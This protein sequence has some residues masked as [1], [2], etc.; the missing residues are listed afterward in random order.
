MLRNR[1]KDNEGPPLEFYYPSPPTAHYMYVM[2]VHV[3]LYRIISFS[4]DASETLLQ[5]MFSGEAGDGGDGGDDGRLLQYYVKVMRL[6]EQVPSPSFAVR[7]AEVAT[8]VVRRDNPAA[9]C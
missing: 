5:S 9:V 4:G 6:F 1:G 8:G 3:M 2:H 7:V